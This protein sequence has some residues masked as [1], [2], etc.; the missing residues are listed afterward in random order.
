M[1]PARL[2]LFWFAIPLLAIVSVPVCG[3]T[4]E[5]GSAELDQAYRALLAKDYDHAI[6]EFR[7][8]LALQ[9]G[10]AMVH[11]DLAY[12]LLKTGDSAE[13]RDEFEAALKLNPR[14]DTAALEYAFLCYET[15]KPI[16][17]RRTFKRL[18]EHG[19]TDATRKTAEQA[20]QNI[21][22]PLAEGIQRWREALAKSADPNA[23]STFSAHWEL[24]QLAEQR[25]ELDL[26]AEQYEICHQLKPNLS[27]LWLD[28]ARV[29]Q[30]VNRV[31]EARSALIAAMWSTDSRTIERAHEAFGNRYP[32]V[33]EFQ[34]AL[35]LDA[36][37]TRLRRELAYLLLALHRE[38]EAI[39]EFEKVVA[40]DPSDHV[41]ANQ[42]ALLRGEKKFPERSANPKPPATD[43]KTMAAKSLALGYMKDAVKYYEQA[44][45]QNPNDPEAVIGLAWA[46]NMS[47][48]DRE[49]IPLFNK[50]RKMD[51]PKVAA[52]AE[53]AYR[54]LTASTQPATTVWAFP[55]YSSRWKDTFGYGQVK[56]RLP[57]FSGLPVQFYTSM[58]F[59][60]DTRETLPGSSPVNPTYLSESAV[61]A[62][63]GV[64]TRSWHHMLA[65]AEAGESISYLPNPHDVARATPDYRGGVNV[66]KGFGQL[67]GAKHSGLFFETTGDAVFISRFDKDWL[68]YSQN[69]T[70]WTFHLGEG[71]SLQV[72]ANANM[73]MDLKN[74]YW[75]NT[76]EVGPG[77]RLR[78]PGMPKNVYLL[79]DYLLGYYTRLDLNPP[80]PRYHDIRIGLWYSFSH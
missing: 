64:S 66:A 47:G 73:T 33:Y 37:N 16:E 60:G 44:L 55:I 11:K 34:K 70:G 69:R 59:I 23:L 21:D 2:S 50:A 6:A 13:A 68:L 10:N 57:F 48:N 72:L 62:G 61:I 53:K 51:D 67:L 45:E 28:L 8:G 20:F 25:D 27:S 71:T 75:A 63:M 5:G 9:P 76:A 30:Q 4:A 40:L 31:E 3:Q 1:L 54:N 80:S 32:Y 24:A 38:P 29:W 42:L 46:Y 18:R 19:A 52:D 79:G 39:Q 17:A 12:T 49:A 7:A 35:A 65:W 14:D 26:A 41:A 77:L 36:Q 58:R 43:A 56:E 78:L 74:Q 15:K 22:R